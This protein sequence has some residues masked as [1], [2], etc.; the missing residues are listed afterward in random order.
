MGPDLSLPEK[1]ASLGSAAPR[2]I[3]VLRSVRISAALSETPL[4]LS[5]IAP[6]LR[7]W[8]IGSYL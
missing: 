7:V 2:I 8:I 3:T 1:A 6:I 4:A 5:S